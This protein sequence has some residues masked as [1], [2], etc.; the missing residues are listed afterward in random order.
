VVSTFYHPVALEVDVQE[1]IFIVATGGRP[2]ALVVGGPGDVG[3]L[4]AIGGDL[5]G[6]AIVDQFAW[7]AAESGDLP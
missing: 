5:G 6:T 1:G 7:I 3:D 4:L 2:E